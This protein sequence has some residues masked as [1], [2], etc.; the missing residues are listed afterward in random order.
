[1]EFIQ[2]LKP[3]VI[4]GIEIYIIWFI[5]YKTLSF[6]KRTK[7]VVIING[8][9]IFIVVGIISKYLNFEVISW[10]YDSVIS[11]SVLI[12][13]FI[14]REEIREILLRIGSIKILTKKR[15]SVEIYAR[16]LKSIIEAI[17][18]MSRENI[19]ALIVFE[20]RIPL[21]DYISTGKEVDYSIT[22]DIVVK[23]FEKTSQY[24]DGAMIIRGLKIVGIGCILPI[25]GVP[26]DLTPDKIN[27]R[28][29]T[30]HRAGYATSR[31]TD[32]IVIIVSEETGKISVAMD[33]YFDYDVDLEVVENVLKN[34]FETFAR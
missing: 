12:L 13:V 16:E 11:Y 18:K 27:K 5:L 2:Y 29:G 7:S 32:A 6:L 19:G 30:R 10:F 23:T 17:D 14:F 31:E 9:V 26:P 3:Y 8:I 4:G 20:R 1:M 22:R 24:H 33:A 28:L 15:T 25:G 21:G 34:Y